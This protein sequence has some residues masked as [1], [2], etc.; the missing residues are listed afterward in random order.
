MN[1]FYVTSVFQHLAVICGWGAFSDAGVFTTHK[2]TVRSITDLIKINYV[3]HW[4][5]AQNEFSLNIKT[6][7]D[8][9]WFD[10]VKWL[11]IC[12]VMGRSVWLFLRHKISYFKQFFKPCFL[13]VFINIT[14]YL[15]TYFYT[16]PTWYSMLVLCIVWKCIIA[17]LTTILI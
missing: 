1:R 16:E 4:R 9:L 15:K 14:R 10:V 3:M 8:V 12:I 7:V 17:F 13:Y 6:E 2:A 5:S 11:F